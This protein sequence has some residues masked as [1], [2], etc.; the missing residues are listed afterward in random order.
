MLNKCKHGD[1][2]TKKY[3]GDFNFE[4]IIKILLFVMTNVQYQK[5]IHTYY[6]VLSLRYFTPKCVLWIASVV[7]AAK[8]CRQRALQA[9]RKFFAASP[10]ISSPSAF[11]VQRLL[12]RVLSFSFMAKERPKNLLFYWGG[13]HLV[14]ELLALQNWFSNRLNL[15]AKI[16]F[17]TKFGQFCTIGGPIWSCSVKISVSIR[18]I[19]IGDR[20]YKEHKTFRS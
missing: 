8:N 18:D 11:F 9:F 20:W 12:L 10:P 16:I 6:T 1:K 5:T 17:A 15:C 7:V 14:R 19:N 2:Q 13:E 3:T 4:R